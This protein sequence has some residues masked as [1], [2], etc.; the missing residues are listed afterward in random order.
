ML[1]NE[2][3]PLVLFVVEFNFFNYNLSKVEKRFLKRTKNIRELRKGHSQIFSRR[4]LLKLLKGISSKNLSME[5]FLTKLQSECWFLCFF[6]ESFANVFTIDFSRRS[7]KKHL[8]TSALK[9]FIKS[10][11]R[12]VMSV[13]LVD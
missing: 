3:F 13:T 8:N 9:Y 4:A 2:F 5:F 11:V 10:I 12:E 7:G 6:P 1:K